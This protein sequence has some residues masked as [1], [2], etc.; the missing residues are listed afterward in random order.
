MLPFLVAPCGTS[1]AAMGID[2]S[3]GGAGGCLRCFRV[4]SLGFLTLRFCVSASSLS[5]GSS[6]FPEPSE[7]TCSAS[8]LP[9]S[10]SGGF[11]PGLM[12]G[13][14]GSF[15]RHRISASRASIQLF[16]LNDL[17]LKLCDQL[18][19]LSNELQ[20]AFRMQM[21]EFRKSHGENVDDWLKIS[22]FQYFLL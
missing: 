16:I 2:S 6:E 4:F 21:V 1:I 20:E 9:G 19:L 12:S 11:V 5:S 15:F 10:S 3:V 18:L 14:A 8:E 7:P 13:F 22:T 17:L